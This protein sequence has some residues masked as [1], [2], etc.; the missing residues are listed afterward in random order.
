MLCSSV[1]PALSPSLQPCH[2]CSAPDQATADTWTSSSIVR[3]GLQ[4]RLQ[5]ARQ[6]QDEP[7]RLGLPALRWAQR[8]EASPPGVER[9]QHHLPALP[10]EG[11]LVSTCGQLAPP[12]ACPVSSLA[13]EQ[14]VAV[15]KRASVHRQAV[16]HGAAAEP[17]GMGQCPLLDTWLI[18]A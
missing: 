15:H 8:K 17:K 3:E 9:S 7:A 2:F 14:D 10:A 4:E 13:L 11:P 5:R 12:Q 1:A 16:A 6:Q 18:C